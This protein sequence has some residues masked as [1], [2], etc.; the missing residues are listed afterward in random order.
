[1]IYVLIWLVESRISH[2][3][4][5][6]ESEQALFEVHAFFYTLFGASVV[7]ALLGIISLIGIRSRKDAFWIFPA[8]II[9]LFGNY[10]TA[11]LSLME[12]GFWSG[13]FGP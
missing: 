13:R 6:L 12:V 5:P 8:T 2:F 7:C 9:G 10:W 11:M 4:R 3:S 1:V